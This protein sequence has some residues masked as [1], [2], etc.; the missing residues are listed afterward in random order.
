MK[1]LFIQNR[2]GQKVSVVVEGEGNTKGLAFVMHGLGGLKK[3]P[4][5]QIMTDA[6]LENGF[7]A[8]SFDTT[9]AYG[10][11]DGE[12]SD[13]TTT[14]YYEDLEDV[15]SW[16]K[17]E[18]WYQEPFWLA[19]HSLGGLCT[20]LYAEKYPEKVRNLAPIST[21]ISGHLRVEAHLE[22]DPEDFKR[23]KETGLQIKESGTIPGL[24]K[25]LKYAFMEDLQK[26]DLIPDANKL[27]M[28]VLLIVGEN[29]TSI[30]PKHQKIFFDVLPGPKEMHV[31]KG[32][33][34]TF[35]DS[36]HLEEIKKIFD[37]WIKNTIMNKD[38]LKKKL[39][40]EQYH[41][42]QEKGT[43][44]PFTGKFVEHKEKGMYTCIVCRAPLFPSDTKFDSGTGWPSFDNAL[45]GAVTLEED[46]AHGMH[47]TEI[48]C[49]KCGAHLGHIFDDGPTESGKRYCTNSCALDFK[50]K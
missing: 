25:R 36:K 42:T 45:P 15:I 10:E 37:T 50:E 17:T 31:I 13:A 29:D 27:S 33:P 28:P 39:S 12:P 7:T 43:E 23:W 34:H 18:E 46:D 4:H 38:D 9:N 22:H 48:T 26:Y 8:V 5:L 32:A 30:P 24:M 6:F 44:A 3:R 47:R 11:S 21:A 2:K 41:V 19:G 1:K 16:A 20:A 35:R 14:N 49:A 40:P